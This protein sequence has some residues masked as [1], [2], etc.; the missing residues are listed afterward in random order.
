MGSLRGCLDFAQHTLTL[1][2]NGKVIP[3][4]MSDVGHYFLSVADFPSPVFSASAFHY[5]PT[6]Q[7]KQPMDLTRNGGFRWLD[8]PKPPSRLAPTTFISPQLFSEC[9]AVT[10]R[11]AGN[12]EISDPA[13]VIT[14]LHIDRAMLQPLR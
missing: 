3:L 2:A 11:D 12:A 8:D 13:K 1:G 6:N 5:A 7:A 4:E 9:K 10:L 14:K